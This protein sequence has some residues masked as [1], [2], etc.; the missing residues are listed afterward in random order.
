MKGNTKQSETEIEKKVGER[1]KNASDLCRTSENLGN[2]KRQ[3]LIMRP[4]MFSHVGNSSKLLSPHP[5]DSH[6]EVASRSPL[7]YAEDQK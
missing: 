2:P 3:R 4:T 7:S 6:P 1:I 5:A